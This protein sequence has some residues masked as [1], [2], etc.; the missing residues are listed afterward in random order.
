MGHWFDEQLRERMRRDR[1]RFDSAFCGLASVIMGERFG[2][3]FHNDRQRVK[4]AVDEVLR[5]FRIPL[6]PVPETAEDLDAY[7]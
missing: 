1:D 5:Y 4:N 2:E 7:L 3:R 6:T